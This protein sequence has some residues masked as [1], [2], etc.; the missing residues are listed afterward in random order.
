MFSSKKEVNYFDMFITSAEYACTASEDLLEL[1]KNYTDVERKVKAIHKIEDDADQHFHL[2]YNH[3]MRSFMTPIDREDI[4]SLAQKIDD[5]IDLIEDIAYRFV[6][7]DIKEVTPETI[8]FVELIVKNTDLLRTAVKEFK[9]FAKSKDLPT[10]I[11]QINNIE[12]EGDT[13]YQ[14]TVRKLFQTSKDPIHLM[15]WREIYHK[16]EDTLDGC[17]AVADAMDGVVVKNT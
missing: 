6:M 3:L 10:K 5:V 14:Q 16:M 7:F 4:M 9:N 12:A 15:I 11:I 1:V 13:Y 2:L 8:P 17:E